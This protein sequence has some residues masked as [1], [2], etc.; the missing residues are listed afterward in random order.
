MAL[1]ACQTSNIAMTVV[2]PASVATS[3]SQ[4]TVSTASILQKKGWN[5]FEAMMPPMLKEAGGRG[6]DL[7]LVRVR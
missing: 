1:T 5:F 4:I 7:P 3:A 6:S 2:L